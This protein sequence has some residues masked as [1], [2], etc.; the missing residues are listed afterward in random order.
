MASLLSESAS[1]RHLA[2]ICVESHRSFLTFHRSLRRLAQDT[3]AVRL[4][5]A[6]A[7]R[8]QMDRIQARLP[9]LPAEQVAALLIGMSQLAESLAEGEFDDL[10]L[11]GE[12]AY[13]Q[14]A[15][16]IEQLR[17]R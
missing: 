8:A 7:R 9:H 10:G 15:H 2:E 17:P 3:P 14:L 12:A 5:T 4:A 11:S 13:G 6:Q 1:S 16:W